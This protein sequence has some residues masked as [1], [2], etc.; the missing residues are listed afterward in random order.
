M[1]VIYLFISEFY[2]S[3]IPKFAGVIN[4]TVTDNT[5][6]NT[7]NK[8]VYHI[9]TLFGKKGSRARGGTD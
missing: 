5:L 9:L 4:E 8:R 3:K 6:Y 2:L 7:I 1:C